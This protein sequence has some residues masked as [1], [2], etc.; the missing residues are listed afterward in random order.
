MKYLNPFKP[1]AGAEP[2]RIIGRDA[3]VM[4]F[5]QGLEEGPGSP[6]R[7]MRISGPRGSGKTVLLNDLGENAREHGWIV[8]D[9]T[10][11]PEMLDDLKYILSSRAEAESGSLGIDAGVV[12]AELKV[13]KRDLSLRDRLHVACRR[14]NGLL[15]TIDEVQDASIDD[16]RRIAQSVQHLIREKQNIALAFAGLPMGVMDVINGKALTFLRRA[17]SEELSPI[18]AVEVALSLRDSF[19]QTGLVLGDEQQ[20]RAAKATEGYAYMIQLVGYYVWQRADIHRNTSVDV[21]SRDVEEGIAIARAQ[22]E[23]L[24]LETALGGIGRGAMEYVI[25]MTKDPKISSTAQVAARLGKTS[26]V[27]GAYRHQLIQRQVIQ[28]VSRGYVEFAV[29]FMRDYVARNKEE[30]MLRYGG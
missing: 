24:V 14:A 13:K 12:S 6:G 22:F 30:L 3:A 11:G 27:A 19:A 25:A 23:Q 18:N 26:K 8:V 2:P 7:L 9:V 10:V 17:I 28:P 5:V 15:V 1:T 21:T 20:A 4:T 16:M 29:P